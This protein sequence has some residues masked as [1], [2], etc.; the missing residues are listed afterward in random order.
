MVSAVLGCACTTHIVRAQ[1][2]GNLAIAS[3]LRYTS[4]YTRPSYTMLQNGCYASARRI[5]LT[6][7]IEWLLG[8]NALRA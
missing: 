8:G 7:S 2:E 4:R 5:E 3:R 1:P 6:R